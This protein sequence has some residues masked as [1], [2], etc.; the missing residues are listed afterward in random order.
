MAFYSGILIFV[1]NSPI[2]WFLKRQNTVKGAT[3][4]SELVAMRIAKNLIIGLEYLSCTCLDYQLMDQQ[5]Y[6]VIIM[7]L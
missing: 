1:Q 5:M 2:I 3:F 7:V 4:G 6:F